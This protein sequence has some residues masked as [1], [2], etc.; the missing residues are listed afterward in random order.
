[1][2]LEE[3]KVFLAGCERGELRDHAFGDAEVWWTKDGANVAGGYFGE[4]SEVSIDGHGAFR[5]REA[6]EL[7]SVGKLGAVE[8]NDST[9]PA[10]FVQGQVMPG[11]SP[12]GVYEE[13]TG[14]PYPK[15]EN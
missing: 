3:A 4:S 15:G 12:A 2:T 7:R 6:D 8:R 13:L 1:M 14:S 11:L 5:G 9:G 10:E